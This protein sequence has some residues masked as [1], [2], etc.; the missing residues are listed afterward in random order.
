[1]RAEDLPR[2]LKK[3]IA[4]LYVLH[5]DEAFLQLEAA[6]VLR[7]H[8]RA[9]DYAEREVHSVEGAHFNWAA[10]LMSAQA[11][12]LF[13]DKKLIELR[14]PSGKPGVEGAKVLE[15]YAAALPPDTV[16]L[17]TLP[18]LDKTAQNSKWFQALTSAG[19]PI[20]TRAV[21]R[22]ALPAWLS[23]RFEM[24]QQHATRDALD[25]L[26]ENVEGNLFAAHQ[27]VLKLGL[28][29][30]PGELSLERIQEAVANVARFDVFQLGT[31]LWQGDAARLM[32]MLAGLRAE[33]E[34]P[35]LVAWA[36][37]EEIRT[38]IKLHDGRQRGA[39]TGALLK[40]LRIWGDKQKYAD[41]ALARTTPPML[42]EALAH[43][44]RIDQINKGVG[45]GD[46]WDEL[47]TLA[48]QLT[49]HTR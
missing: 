35:H 2:A 24:Q 46:A 42:R 25:F 23:G 27:E 30:P 28:L 22:H 14:I 18:R 49:T 37:T 36:M 3:E 48:L 6:Q 17:I 7:D 44:A 10:L 43:A 15:A 41:A 39:P 11:M 9:N 21:E 5:G 20:E 38:L 13:A 47:E 32:R 34:A 40:E 12:S 19:V 29:Y 33:G 26:A 31:T 8:L 4:P 1:M 16:T 45:E